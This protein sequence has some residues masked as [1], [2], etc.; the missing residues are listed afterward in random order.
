MTEEERKPPRSKW[1]L[2]LY[3]PAGLIVLLALL[4]LLR[5]VIVE[6]RLKSYV[7]TVCRERL[8]A[9]GMEGLMMR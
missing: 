3:L 9:Q 1:R 8:V 4:Y 7:Q 6:H 5:G 2:A